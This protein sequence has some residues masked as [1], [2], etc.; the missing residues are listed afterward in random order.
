VATTVHIPEALLAAVD[1][2]ATALGVSRNRLI[3]HALE[4]A[5]NE[6]AAWSPEFLTRLRTVDAGTR[7]AVD[8]MLIAIQSARRFTSTHGL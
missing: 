6:G 8:L 4:Q 2:R 5:I 7:D 3:V 1:R